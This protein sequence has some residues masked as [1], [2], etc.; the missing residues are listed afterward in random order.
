MRFKEFQVDENPAAMLK[1]LKDLKGLKGMGTATLG[2]AQ[3]VA[4]GIGGMLG[5]QGNKSR[6]PSSIQMK[7]PDVPNATAGVKN[8]NAGPLPTATGAPPPPAGQA[9]QKATAPAQQMAEHN[10]EDMAKAQKAA[11]AQAKAS[12]KNLQQQIKVTKQQLQLM[13]KQLQSIK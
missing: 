13:Q 11:D 4:K 10:P 5:G 8:P 6:G 12:K 1:G 9:P 3:Q 2:K 7:S